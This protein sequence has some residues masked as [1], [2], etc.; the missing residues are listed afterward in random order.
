M[1]VA[2]GLLQHPR[3]AVSELKGNQGL[4]ERLGTIASRRWRV[5]SFV[6]SIISIGAWQRSQTDKSDQC[7]GCRRQIRCV[8]DADSSRVLIELTAPTQERGCA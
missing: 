7:N 5:S 6:A 3:E 8:R 2:T 4:L 1:A